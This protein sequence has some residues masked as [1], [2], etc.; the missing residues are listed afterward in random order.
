LISMDTAFEVIV[1]ILSVFLFIFL[2]LSIAVLTMVLK[3]VK[4]LRQVVAKG[5]HIV[6]SAE[7]IT[8]TLRRNA[9]A[10]GM[11]KML[12]QLMNKKDK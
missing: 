11:I 7:E 3:L 12:M 1:I 5:E 9:G 10:V 2:V 4:S 8:D 6:D